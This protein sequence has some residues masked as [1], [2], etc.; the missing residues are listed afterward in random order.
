[1]LFFCF[2]AC[3]DFCAFRERERQ[4]ERERERGRPNDGLKIF[5][6]LFVIIFNSDPSFFIKLKN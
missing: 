3:L 2:T 6:F 4:R 1:M 5:P